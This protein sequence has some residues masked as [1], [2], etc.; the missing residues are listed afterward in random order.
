MS[1]LA[2]LD[3][4]YP[5]FGLWLRGIAVLLELMVE[6]PEEARVVVKYPYDPYL[7]N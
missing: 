4:E 2:F 3:R 7:M 5:S 1:T 6:P